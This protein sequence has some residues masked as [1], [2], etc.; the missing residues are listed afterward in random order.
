M[1]KIGDI[2]VAKIVDE[3]T[4]AVRS[5]TIPIDIG[6]FYARTVAVWSQ[7]RAVYLR[8]HQDIEYP[9]SRSTA[10]KIIG[11]GILIAMA[12]AVLLGQNGALQELA[13]GNLIEWISMSIALSF[14]VIMIVLSL[15]DRKEAV[16]S[17]IE[18]PPE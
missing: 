3:P 18:N 13:A 6:T 4:A 8:A 14:G 9:I 1:L 5:S 12:S 10:M 11:T 15:P 17:L 16:R 7:T 2:K